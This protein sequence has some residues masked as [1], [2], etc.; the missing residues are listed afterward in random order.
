V[1]YFRLVFCVDAIDC[2]VEQTLKFLEELVKGEE[3][4][5]GFDFL[6]EPPS[7]ICERRFLRTRRRD[8]IVGEFRSWI[9]GAS[10]L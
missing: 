6:S 8:P 9:V 3:A 5:G 4:N 10:A 1:R 7:V 2:T